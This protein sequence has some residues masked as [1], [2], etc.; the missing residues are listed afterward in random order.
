MFAR[1]RHRV[2]R[3]RMRRHRSIRQVVNLGL[4]FLNERAAHV[5][6]FR[7]CA[8]MQLADNIA[9][10][11]PVP[12]YESGATFMAIIARPTGPRL[13]TLWLVF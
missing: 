7:L 4:Y 13:A 8:R 3:L 2:G 12:L 1:G 5:F 10:S 6:S 9:M 11:I